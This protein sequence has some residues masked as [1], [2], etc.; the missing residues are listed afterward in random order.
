MH[1]V[2]KVDYLLSA[3]FEFYGALWLKKIT[4]KD[5]DCYG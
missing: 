4:L 1:K 3:L 5:F 2:R